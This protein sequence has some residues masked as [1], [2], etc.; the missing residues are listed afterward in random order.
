M[1]F[2]YSKYITYNSFLPQQQNIHALLFQNKKIMK[3]YSM[4]RTVVLCIALLCISLGFTNCNKDIKDKSNSLLSSN[5]ESSSQLTVKNRPNII[6]LVANDVGYEMPA[7][8][9]G[10]SY[11]TPTLDMMAANGI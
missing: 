11:Q 6:L 9:G 2:P 4:Q 1:L 5:A 10:K 7:F 8:T 3:F